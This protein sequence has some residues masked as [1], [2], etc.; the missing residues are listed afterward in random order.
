VDVA[1]DEVA[2]GED[3]LDV[4]PQRVNQPDLAW[5]PLEDQVDRFLAKLVGVTPLSSPGRG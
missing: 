5:P 3:P 2:L 1:D 4:R